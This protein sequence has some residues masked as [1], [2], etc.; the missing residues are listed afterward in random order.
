M[1]EQEREI[2]ASDRYGAPQSSLVMAARAFEVIQQQAQEARIDD[3]FPAY[4]SRT[5]ERARAAGYGDD[6]IAS[7]VKTLR[8][9]RS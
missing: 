5:F 9:A 8:A 3:A 4:V 7:I 2:I 6:A 1:M